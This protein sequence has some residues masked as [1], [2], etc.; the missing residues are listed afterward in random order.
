[1]AMPGLLFEPKGPLNHEEDLRFLRDLMDQVGPAVYNVFLLRRLRQRAGAVERARVARDLH[2]GAVQSIIAMEMRVD[3]LRRRLPA[4]PQSVPVADE[5][6]N[7]QQLLREEVLKLREMMQN[8]KSVE[9]DAAN[10]VG[11]CSDTGERF[12][13]ETGIATRFIP[14]RREVELDSRV[15][16]ELLRILQEA[17]VNVRKHSGARNVL[18]RLMAQE[19]QVWRLIVEDDGQGFD[20]TGRLELAA[21][22]EQ[23]RGPLVIKERVRLIGGELA[24]ESNPGSGTRLEVTVRPRSEKAYG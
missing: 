6:S 1:V 7:I 21:L 18:I 12:Q 11:L 3:M 17:L 16:R 2:D 10:L 15:C 20:F 22:D 14:P 4:E 9:A 13:R 8:L 24:I 23:R 19:G 5:L